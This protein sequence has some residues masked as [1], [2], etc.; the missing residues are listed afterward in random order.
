MAGPARDCSRAGA[1][2]GADLSWR[3][4]GLNVPL[5]I[6]SKII[7]H[8]L[9][10]YRSTSNALRTRAP[11]SKTLFAELL[12]GRT[13]VGWRQAKGSGARSLRASNDAMPITRD[14]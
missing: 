10:R 11:H 3:T 14:I 4:S 5:L 1:A 9:A 13:V 2:S 6:N 12:A 7:N 8:F